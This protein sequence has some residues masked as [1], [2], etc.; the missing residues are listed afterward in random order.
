M[1]A[2]M[3]TNCPQLLKGMLDMQADMSQHL[4]ICIRNSATFYL[5][6]CEIHAYSLICPFSL[7]AHTR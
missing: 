7:D 1:N 3:Q 2:A 5:Y 6:W 4:I